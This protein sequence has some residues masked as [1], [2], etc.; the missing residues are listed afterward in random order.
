MNP[1]PALV[2]TLLL[3]P[4]AAFAADT[5]GE[6]VGFARFDYECSMVSSVM[7]CSTFKSATRKKNL[8][9]T[10]EIR[11]Q[12]KALIQKIYET[13]AGILSIKGADEH[14]TF[15]NMKEWKDTLTGLAS[16]YS[17][18][19]GII[20]RTKYDREFARGA[21]P[22]ELESGFV[23]DINKSLDPK[24][25]DIVGKHVEA[26]YKNMVMEFVLAFPRPGPFE[27]AGN[28]VTIPIQN[29]LRAPIKGDD[30]DKA[31]EKF[32]A[33]GKGNLVMPRIK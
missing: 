8:D 5:D 27:S 22:G 26:A 14:A 1:T 15:T 2:L 3:S 19:K 25:E 9:C 4:G 28:Q 13:R 32:L 18:F 20:A 21:F 24:A 30:F 29:A 6:C 10:P 17:S 11:Q 16:E 7:G 12:A 31:V 23:S 33:G